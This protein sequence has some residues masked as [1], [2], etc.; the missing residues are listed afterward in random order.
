MSTRFFLK[1][2]IQTKLYANGEPIAFDQ[3]TNNLGVLKTDDAELLAL[4]DKCI[5]E[6]RG[7]VEEI[8][9]ARYEALI[10]KKSGGIRPLDREAF[11]APPPSDTVTSPRPPAAA[12]KPEPDAPQP[13]APEKKKAKAPNVGGRPPAVTE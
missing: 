4:L 12:V 8:D 13:P 9:Q 10:E 1:E 5:A 11:Q 6:H 7:G 2:A 3:V